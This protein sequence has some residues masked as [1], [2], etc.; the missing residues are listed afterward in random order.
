MI[1][2]PTNNFHIWYIPV[3]SNLAPAFLETVT[4]TLQ[5]TTLSIRVE[6][7]AV[8]CLQC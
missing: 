3:A 1:G 8:H 5:T 6:M 4:I 2:E 7:V